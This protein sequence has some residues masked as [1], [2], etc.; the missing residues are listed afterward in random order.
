MLR[1]FAVAVG[2]SVKSLFEEIDVSEVRRRA[3]FRFGLRAMLIAIA[4]IFAC[5]VFLRFVSGFFCARFY[6]RNNTEYAA[7]VALECPNGVVKSYGTIP[8]HST[9]SRLFWDTGEGS[10]SLYVNQK[11]MGVDSY[12]TSM[13]YDMVVEFDDSGAKAELLL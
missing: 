2:C 10:V 5:A 13:N 3:R 9:R 7:T 8:P 12:V 6:V 1:K 11:W 4:I